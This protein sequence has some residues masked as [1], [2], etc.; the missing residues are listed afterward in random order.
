MGGNEYQN[1]KNKGDEQPLEALSGVFAAAPFAQCVA[2]R[3]ARQQEEKAHLPGAKRINEHIVQ[4]GAQVVI[5]DIEVLIRVEDASSVE[6][7]EEKDGHE[8]QPIDVVETLKFG[9][10]PGFGRR[11]RICAHG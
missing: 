8:A 5:L 3:G 6:E 11:R 2:R 4:I 1:A 9:R 10:W 7:E